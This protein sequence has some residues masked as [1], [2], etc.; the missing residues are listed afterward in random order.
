MECNLSQCNVIEF[1]GT[2]RVD[3]VSARLGQTRQGAT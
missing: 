1:S 3:T 2:A